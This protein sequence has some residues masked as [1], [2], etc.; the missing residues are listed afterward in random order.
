MSEKDPPQPSLKGKDPSKSPLK[1]ETFSLTLREGWGGSV[2]FCFLLV[3]VLSQGLAQLIAAQVSFDDLPVGTIEDGC[4]DALDVVEVAGCTLPSLQVADLR[5]GDAKVLDTL[6]PGFLA[7]VEGDADHFEA[8]VL[9]LL[10]VSL[11]IRHLSAAGTAPACPEVNEDVLALAHVVGEVALLVVEVL[12]HEIYDSRTGQLV[13]LAADG[14]HDGSKC[15][16]V[17]VL[18]VL[19]EVLDG[20]EEPDCPCSP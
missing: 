16:A 5:P 8:F 6:C 9:V 12:T 3:K 11:H 15:L 14:G 19:Q 20:R 7:V 4:R 10:V 18:V 13:L 2:G 1:G 17:L